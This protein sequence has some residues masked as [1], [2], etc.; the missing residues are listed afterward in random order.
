MLNGKSV[1]T[2]LNSTGRLIRPLADSATERTALTLSGYNA[3]ISLHGEKLLVLGLVIWF[4]HAWMER[5]FSVPINSHDM[6][7]YHDLRADGVSGACL[8]INEDAQYV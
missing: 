7:E 2:F 4:I 6:L 3:K 1:A 5:V 8:H